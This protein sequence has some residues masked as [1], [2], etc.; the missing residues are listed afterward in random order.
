MVFAVNMAGARAW[1]AVALWG[2]LVEHEPGFRAEN[3]RVVAIRRSARRVTDISSGASP[4]DPVQVRVTSSYRNRLRRDRLMISEGGFSVIATLWRKP[5]AKKFRLWWS[6]GVLPQIRRTGKYDPR[7][8]A[9]TLVSPAAA[10]SR[11]RPSA[12]LV[13]T[14]PVTESG[15]PGS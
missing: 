5:I 6:E 9:G 1:G 13:Y 14:R 15:W 8:R 3:A 11:E 7:G 4:T 10:L 12:D 2:E